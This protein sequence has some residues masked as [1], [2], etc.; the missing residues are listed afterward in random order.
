MSIER[1]KTYNEIFDKLYRL[2]LNKAMMNSIEPYLES[3][4]LQQLLNSL[5]EKIDLDK[6]ILL[7]YTHIKREEPYLNS[8]EPLQ[9]LF[10]RYSLG[11]ERC[12]QIWRKKCSADSLLLCNNVEPVIVLP[13]QF[14]S[15]PGSPIHTSTTTVPSPSQQPPPRP[16][17]PPPP[18]FVKSTLTRSMCEKDESMCSV[19]NNF[20]ISSM[21]PSRGNLK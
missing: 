4:K 20:N 5:Y 7:V 10:K 17:P 12:I 16:R 6:E 11:F 1:W 14:I 9:P 18:P 8:L 2:Y 21:T 13:D 15:S 3:I 19:S